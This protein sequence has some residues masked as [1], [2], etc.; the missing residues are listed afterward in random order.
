[1][2]KEVNVGIAD[3]RAGRNPTI[4]ITIGLGSCVG[5]A[6]YDAT[7][8]IGALAHIMLPSSKESANSENRAKFADTAIPLAMDMIK[9]LGGDAS[10]LTAKIAGGANMFSFSNSEATIG[11]RNVMAVKEALKENKVKLIGEDIGGKIGRTMK[12]DLSTGRVIIR[13]ARGEREL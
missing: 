8:K 2:S 12:F 11:E 5:I 3:V 4:L 6:L 1:M 9:K 7:N 13:T 10:K